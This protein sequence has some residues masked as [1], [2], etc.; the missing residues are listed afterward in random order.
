MAGLG[1]Q[2]PELAGWTTAGQ[3]PWFLAFLF[4]HVL[5]VCLYR[6]GVELV[7]IALD[8]AKSPLGAFAKAGSKTVTVRVLHE[9]RF[10]INDFYSPFGTGNHTIATSVATLFVN[11]DYSARG[12]HLTIL[13]NPNTTCGSFLVM[14]A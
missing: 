8:N 14:T 13:R 4:F 5:Q 10:S 2:G 3:V 7:G 11:F 6:F 9:L 12:L 1:K